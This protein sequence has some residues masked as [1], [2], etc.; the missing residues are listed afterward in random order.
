LPSAVQLGEYV[1]C[2]RIT[3]RRIEIKIDVENMNHRNM[4]TGLKWKGDVRSRR[5]STCDLGNDTLSAI[6]GTQSGVI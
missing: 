5:G 2:H 3:L 6:R 1:A 4:L